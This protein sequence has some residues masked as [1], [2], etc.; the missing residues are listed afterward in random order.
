MKRLR[1]RQYSFK[2]LTQFSVGNI[3]VDP[4]VS[5]IDALLTREKVLVPLT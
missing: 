4:P 5:N 2:K 1:G 3:V